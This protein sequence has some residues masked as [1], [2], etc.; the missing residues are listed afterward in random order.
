VSAGLWNAEAGMTVGGRHVANWLIGQV[1]NKAH[2]DEN[3]SWD[4]TGRLS[5]HPAGSLHRRQ[6]FLANAVKYP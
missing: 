4:I 3:C 6:H 1:R 2:S 5:E